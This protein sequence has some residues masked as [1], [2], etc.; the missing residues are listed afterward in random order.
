[1]IPSEKKGRQADH[2]RWNI[3]NN[4]AITALITGIFTVIAAFVA[5]AFKGNAIGLAPS[6]RV[7]VTAIQ[8]ITAT[9]SPKASIPVTSPSV[10]AQQNPS[11]TQSAI[12][13][14]APKNQPGWTLAWHGPETIGP[15]GIIL[16]LTGPQVSNGSNFNIQYVPGSGNG[17]VTGGNWGDFGYWENNY[18][19][20]PATINGIVQSG[21]DRTDPRDQQAQIGDRLMYESSDKT[22]VSYMQITETPAGDVIA[23]MWLWDKS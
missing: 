20:G 9:T 19:P 3:S 12:P 5:G 21:D 8:T 17:W 2:R 1:M 4:Q 13:I 14:L 22:I 16:A 10:Q 6:P 23:D 15:Q 7:T 11:P 18:A